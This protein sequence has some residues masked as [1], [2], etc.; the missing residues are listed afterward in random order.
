MLACVTLR[1]VES[2]GQGRLCGRRRQLTL[3]VI[4][5]HVAGCGRSDVVVASGKSVTITS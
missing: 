4:F 5:F 2:Y 3:K 1:Y